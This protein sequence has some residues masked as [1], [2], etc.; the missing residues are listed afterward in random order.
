MWVSGAAVA[1][2][3]SFIMLAVMLAAL[4]FDMAALTMGNLA[5]AA[6]VVIAFSPHEVVGPGFQMS[7]AATAALIAGYAV[8]NVWREKRQGNT[9][10]VPPAPA[11][12]RLLRVAV[13]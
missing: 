3:R 6:L 5:I 13:L 7:F 2:Q 4:L 10:G 9:A 12:L 11:G 1:A 8:W